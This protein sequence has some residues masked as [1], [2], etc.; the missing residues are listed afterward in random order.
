MRRL[1]PLGHLIYF[2]I[3]F[4]GRR[5]P[6]S[7]TA[8]QPIIRTD[9]RH[10]RAD[11]RDRR[12][13]GARLRH[14]RHALQTRDVRQLRQ[15]RGLDFRLQ[16][17]VVR[18]LEGETAQGG[19]ADAL[20]L[21]HV[22]GAPVRGADADEARLDVLA[23]PLEVLARRTRLVGFLVLGDVQLPAELLYL[24]FHLLLDRQE[25]TEQRQARV[26]RSLPC[27]GGLGSLRCDC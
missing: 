10:V 23:G 9:P 13:R 21:L 14:F 22:G 4:S 1:W 5:L 6:A 19:V 18:A 12:Q 8:P 25:V 26:W 15:V 17:G 2:L 24:S 20:A 3:P 7:L 16:H 11:A 27:L